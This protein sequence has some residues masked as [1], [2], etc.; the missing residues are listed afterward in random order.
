M[1][2]CSDVD[3][4]RGHG[5]AVTKQELFFVHAEQRTSRSRQHMGSCLCVAGM[6]HVGICG[7]VFWDGPQVVESVHLAAKH[8]TVC[9]RHVH[10]VHHIV[11]TNTS[12]NPPS[13]SFFHMLPLTYPLTHLCTYTH[14]GRFIICILGCYLHP[15]LRDIKPNS[16][17]PPPP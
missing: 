9:H 11:F 2:I 3:R 6:S 17:P 15:H 1:V 5:P 10:Q 4:R 12:H 13:H 16:H 14:C 8:S 7:G